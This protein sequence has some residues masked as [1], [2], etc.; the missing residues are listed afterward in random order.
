MMVFTVCV[1]LWFF[2]GQFCPEGISLLDSKDLKC[3]VGDSY[4]EEGYT[5]GF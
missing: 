5:L 1:W 3:S 4:K 2:S